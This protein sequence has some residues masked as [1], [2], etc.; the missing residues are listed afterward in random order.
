M[1]VNPDHNLG[2]LAA[3]NRA[4]KAEN[5][6]LREL[7]SGKRIQRPSDDPAGMAAL[8][9]VQ[10]TDSTTTQYLSTIKALRSQMQA[11]DSSLGSV[12]TALNRA[13]ELGVRGGTGTLSDSDRQAVASELDGITDQL[14]ELANT[15]SQGVYLFAGTS[16]TSR[17][18][19][20]VGNAITYQGSGHSNEV[21]IS[22]GVSV[23]TNLAGSTVFGSDQSGLFSTMA[24]LSNAIRNNDPVDSALDSLKQVQDLVSKARVLYGNS[25]NQIDGSESI[26]SERH[27]Q[28]AQQETELAGSDLADV[29]TRLSAAETSRSALLATLAKGSQVNLFD[30]LS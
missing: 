18:F 21:A 8:V 30:F 2:M 27:L 6:A 7:G 5:V 17:A 16:T 26:L 13:L 1:R 22:D 10:A 23:D 29:A 20:K 24:G 28:L 4:T 14:L 11:S 9:E 3:L 19:A 15:S 25:L 12:T